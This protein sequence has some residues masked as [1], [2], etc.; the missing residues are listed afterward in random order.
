[1]FAERL[2]LSVELVNTILMSLDS[3]FCDTFCKLLSR[4]NFGKPEATDFVR[5]AL[6]LCFWISSKRRS[7]AVFLSVGLGESDSL[8]AE[9]P[10][11]SDSPVAA[12]R[13]SFVCSRSFCLALSL[14]DLDLLFEDFF[15]QRF[16]TTDIEQSGELTS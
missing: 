13:S 9:D 5:S 15:L 1:M 4:I 12:K 10:E 11:A 8:G 6:T 16:S 3:H 14:S 2:Q 7:A